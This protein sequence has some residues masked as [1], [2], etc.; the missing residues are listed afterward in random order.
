MA[1]P[2]STRISATSTQI[3]DVSVIGHF[4]G[5]K[6]ANNGWTLSEVDLAFDAKLVFT[7]GNHVA[8][9]ANVK[10]AV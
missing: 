6:F 9:K 4:V 8:V 5:K 7:D 10:M 3:T 2:A 1:P